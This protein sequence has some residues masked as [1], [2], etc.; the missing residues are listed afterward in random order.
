[1]RLTNAMQ[2][3]PYTSEIIVYRAFVAKVMGIQ[4]Q[5][6]SCYHGDR[7]LRDQLMKAI[8]ISSVLDSLKDRV[9]RGAQKLVNRVAKRLSDKPRTA[10]ATSA[11]IANAQRE[12]FMSSQ[13]SGAN[14]T[15][16]QKY[17]GEAKRQVKSFGFRQHRGGRGGRR[18]GAGQ[19]RP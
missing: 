19:R 4:K 2:D 6:D 7:Y 13:D 18:Y 16:G 8:D 3:E 15:L 1:M 14:Y 12:L 5:L 11:Y 10:R 9:P 17:G